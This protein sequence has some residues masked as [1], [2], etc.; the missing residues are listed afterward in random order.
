MSKII[1][2][3]VTSTPSDTDTGA[4]MVYLKGDYWRGKRAGNQETTFLE[5][6][7]GIVFINSSTKVGIGHNTPAQSLTVV[8]SVSADS[9]KFPDGT[10]QTTAA[11]VNKYVADWATSHGSVTVANGSTHTITHNLGTT[12]VIVQVYVNSSASDTNAQRID[13]GDNQ[14]GGSDE[15]GGVVTSLTSNTV[16]VQLGAG[17]YRDWNSDGEGSATTFGSKYI[18]AV[19]IG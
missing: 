10:E 11:T 9:Y 3:D 18:K 15:V 14:D 8:G 12:D 7:G 1:F 5:V 19:V 16:V 13:E 4:G 17:G 6:S 2:T